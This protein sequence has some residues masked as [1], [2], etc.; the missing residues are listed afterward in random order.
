MITLLCPHLLGE[1]W[2][3]S[4]A[5]I[6]PLGTRWLPP[7]CLWC[8]GWEGCS[9]GP[10]ALHPCEPPALLSPTPWVCQN[11]AF[12]PQKP[13]GVAVRGRGFARA[14]PHRVS[15]ARAVEAAEP[16]PPRRSFK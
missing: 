7:A 12:W 8:Q 11:T 9:W 4:V 3:S 1:G 16:G 2:R 10:P 6:P 15:T 14:L 5:K 13:I